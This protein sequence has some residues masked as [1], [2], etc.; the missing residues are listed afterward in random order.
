MARKPKRVSEPATLTY[1]TSL[2]RHGRIVLPAAVRRQL[3]LTP[4]V[5]LV[6]RVEGR[7]VRLATTDVVIDAVQAA[8]RKRLPK[9]ISLVDTLIQWRR[10]G[11]WR[12]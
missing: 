5:E 11:G 3:G 4:G 8:A 2:D 6:V 1:G 7:E 10:A 9:G 12:E